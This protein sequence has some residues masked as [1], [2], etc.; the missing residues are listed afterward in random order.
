VENAKNLF[1]ST[2]LDDVMTVERLGAIR[3]KFE[4]EALDDLSLAIKNHVE[5]HDGVTLVDIVKFL[6]QSVLGSLHILDHM[7]EPE[8]E[9]WIEKNF[10]THQPDKGPLT[11]NLYG[12]KWVRLNLGAFKHR[13]GPNKKLLVRLF[14]TGKE[15]ERVSVAKFSSKMREVFKLVSTGKVRA[16]N[17][18]R[19]LPDLASSFLLEYERMGYPP[20]HHSRSYSEKNP[21]Y[22]VVPRESLAQLEHKAD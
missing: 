18:T 13:Y 10:A 20:L 15:K 2:V 9:A 17:S 5:A 6:Y 12:D 11:E 22:I 16:S 19:S 21:E 8:I 7:S 3:V 1:V 14:L 4:G